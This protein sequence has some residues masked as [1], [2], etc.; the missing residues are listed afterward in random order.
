MTDIGCADTVRPVRIAV[1]IFRRKKY[2]CGNCHLLVREED[3][4][5]SFCGKRIDWRWRIDGSM[6]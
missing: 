1:G 2:I 5:C 3:R 4:Y 6:Y